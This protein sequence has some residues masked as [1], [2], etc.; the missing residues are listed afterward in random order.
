MQALVK[1]MI[2]HND[3]ALLENV[4]EQTGSNE[5]RSIKWCFDIGIEHQVCFMS[6]EH[7]GI[8]CCQFDNRIENITQYEAASSPFFTTHTHT[9]P[10]IQ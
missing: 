2:I 8:H 3:I 1:S 7:H 10:H 4:K 6:Q 5:H 9:N